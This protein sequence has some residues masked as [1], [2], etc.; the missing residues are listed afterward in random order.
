MADNKDDAAYAIRELLDEREQLSVDR[1]VLRFPE[2]DTFDGG[3]ISVVLIPSVDY[4]TTLMNLV[5]SPSFKGRKLCYVSL[6]RPFSSLASI[7]EKNEVNLDNV[8]I[9]DAVTQTVGTSKELKNVVFVSSPRSLTELGI[10]IS[11]AHEVQNF[12]VLLFDSISVL[13]A[14]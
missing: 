8:L 13:M 12:E 11:E 4:A 6:S 5:S 1:K 14:H 2:P 3:R 9:I 10:R 7:L